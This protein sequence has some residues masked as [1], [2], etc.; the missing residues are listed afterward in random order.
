MLWTDHV[1]FSNLYWRLDVPT[2]FKWQSLCTPRR[3]P[4][5]VSSPQRKGGF[6]TFTEWYFNH[7]QMGTAESSYLQFCQMQVISRK[8]RPTYPGVLLPWSYTPGR[9]CM[10]THI[11]MQLRS[12]ITKKLANISAFVLSHDQKHMKAKFL[13]MPAAWSKFYC[14]YDYVVGGKAGLSHMV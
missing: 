9:N 2:H 4:P 7:W 11:N 13:L 6:S 8:R 1:S 5:T 14:C 10:F 3:W 12:C